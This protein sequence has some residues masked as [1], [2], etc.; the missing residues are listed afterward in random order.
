M[1]LATTSIDPREAPYF[2]YTRSRAGLC[3]EQELDSARTM[4]LHLKGNYFIYL[5][6]DASYISFNKSIH[7]LCIRFITTRLV[8]CYVKK[9]TTVFAAGEAH[10]N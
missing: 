3:P 6:K 7:I 5:T 1:I 10:L 9:E 8:H 4:P 2:F